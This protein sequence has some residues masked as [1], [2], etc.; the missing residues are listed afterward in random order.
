MKWT[1]IFAT[2][3]ALVFA[4]VMTTGCNSIQKGAAAGG[5]LG[6]AVGGVVAHNYTSMAVGQGIAMGGAAGAAT[7]G[8]AGDAYRQMTEDDVERELQNLRAELDSKNQELAELRDAGATADTLAEMDM[9]RGELDRT[10]SDLENARTSLDQRTAEVEQMNNQIDQMAEARDQA[11]SRATAMQTQLREVEDQ[12]A[13]A[14]NQVQTIQASLREKEQGLNQLRAQLKDLNVQLD[15]T[16]RGLTMTIVNELLYKPGK[17]ELS[18][19]GIELMSQIAEI[20]QTNFP[21][22]ELLVEGHT[23]NEPIQYSSWKSNWELGAARALT[24]VHEL[25]E[26]QGFDPSRLSATSYGEYRP[27]APN[28]TPDGR[29]QNRRSVIV[30]LPEKMPLQRTTLASL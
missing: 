26:G 13:M 24:V 21:N 30:I 7:G 19:E 22:R 6:A 16:N 2:A 14:R 15:E 8:L 10:I 5:A 9:L 4:L 25:V 12:L 27:I 28:A 11:N 20:I 18:D 17:A 1:R 23:D 3:G 29:A